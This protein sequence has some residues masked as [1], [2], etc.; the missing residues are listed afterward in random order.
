MDFLKYLNPQ[1]METEIAEEGKTPAFHDIMKQ[2]GLKEFKAYIREL[3]RMKPYLQKWNHKQA[4]PT[5]HILLAMNSGDGITTVIKLFYE[6]LRE[7]KLFYCFCEEA[8][9]YFQ[10]TI[11]EDVEKVNTKVSSMSRHGFKKHHDT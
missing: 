10:E 8:E 7:N 6:Y 3:D 11:L 9:L 1:T 4:Y 2:V 5:E